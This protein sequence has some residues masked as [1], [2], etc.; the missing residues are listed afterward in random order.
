MAGRFSSDGVAAGIGM[1]SS[2]WLRSCW[3]SSSRRR[4]R[5]NRGLRAWPLREG[6]SASGVT[7]DA[8]AETYGIV[9][10]NSVASTNSFTLTADSAGV[11]G[12]ATQVVVK[13]DTREGVFTIDVYNDSNQVE[14]WGNLVKDSSSR[15]YVETFLT[16]VSD[17]VRVQDNTATLAPPLDGTYSLAGGSDGIPSD[18]DDQDALI[19]GNS[20]SYSGLYAL[21]EP[22][23]IDI[24][25]I[26]VPGHPSTSIV[27]A[28]LDVCENF[29]QDCLALIDPPFGLTVDEI[30]QWQNGAHPLNTTRFDSDFGALYWPWVKVRD[31][32]NR[33]DVWV[34][35]SGSVMAVYARSDQLAEPWFA[36]AGA[37]RG[38]VPGISD[39]YSRP[40]LEERDLMYG[41]RNA[42]NPI[43]N[44]SD[45]DGLHFIFHFNCFGNVFVFNGSQ[46]V[47]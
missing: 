23:Q 18:P 6:A 24:D 44:F 20:L 46:V 47:V 8:A 5:A 1:T 11:D 28:M 22:E 33:V 12:N 36:P 43:V 17:W 25:L 35:P 37:N 14:S 2:A 29:R 41:N 7:G 34:P 4:R 21:S 38:I 40:T 45:F 42:V 10:G 15:F 16:L 32:F 39:V 31:N 9:T 19:I 30:V 27:L 26:A 13:N 3:P